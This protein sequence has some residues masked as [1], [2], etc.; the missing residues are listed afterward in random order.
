MSWPKT[1]QAVSSSPVAYPERVNSRA[2]RALR[3]T[4]LAAFATLIA[5]LAHTLGGGAAPSPLFCAALFAFAAPLATALAGARVSLR[6]TIAAVAASQ[7]L[8]HGAFAALGDFG[9]STAATGG[10]LHGVVPTL[11]VLAPAPEHPDMTFAH[12]LAGL[13]TVAAVRRGESIVRAVRTWILGTAAPPAT[14]IVF[15]RVPRRL[16]HGP[17]PLLP[18]LVVLSGLSRRG[19]PVRL[20]TS[21]AA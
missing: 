16:A 19:P 5:A 10:H 8:F 15:P 14:S 18:L 17:S 21:F 6:G 2:A 20:T 9:S 12:V 3:G 11:S 4:A 1:T 7:L 13:V